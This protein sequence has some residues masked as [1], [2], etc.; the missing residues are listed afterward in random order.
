MEWNEREEKGGKEGER[1]RR[2]GTEEIL[3]VVQIGDK[4]R[5]KMRVSSYKQEI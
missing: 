1:R 4:Q 5:L 3:A 2:R